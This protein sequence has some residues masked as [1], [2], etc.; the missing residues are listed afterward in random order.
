MKILY[1][2]LI[3]YYFI[4]KCNSQTIQI[5]YYYN[6]KYSEV[7][8]KD[9]LLGKLLHQNEISTFNFPKYYFKQNTIDFDI[10]GNIIGEIDSLQNQVYKNF[11]EKY[12]Y[13]YSDVLFQKN[14][15]I[16]E[17]IIDV[18]YTLTGNRKIILG[19]ECSEAKFD[20]KG[21]TYF[22]Y[23]TESIPIKDGPWKFYGLPGL[24][25]EVREENDLIHF[26]AIKINQLNDDLEIAPIIEL[27]NT[28]S[29][30][31]IITDAK[32]AYFEYKECCNNAT[33][34]TP[35]VIEMYDL[36]N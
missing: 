3:T 36:N 7:N 5:D 8:P 16:K 30:E 26:W 14:V 17:P 6:Y 24:I 34:Y 21:R 18:K 35:N 20:Y 9:T 13:S 1:L 25:L 4:P 12:I 28:K 19:F 23:F 10:D 11:K 2:L 33:I 29:W 22:A 15:T 31:Q 27:T 32:K